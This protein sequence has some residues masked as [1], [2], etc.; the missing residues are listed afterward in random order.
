MTP[1]EEIRTSLFEGEAALITSGAN[2]FYLTGF[3]SSAGEILVTR[4]KAYFLVDF[5]YI[6]AA[7]AAVREAEVILM[8]ALAAQRQEL[9]AAAGVRTLYI[10]TEKASVRALAGYRAAHPTVTVSEDG[11]PG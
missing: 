5:R 3:P 10:E 1:I 9:L 7:R 2:R 11:R 6:E 4:E 8:Q